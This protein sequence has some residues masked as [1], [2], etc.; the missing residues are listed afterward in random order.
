M[1]W[2]ESKRDSHFSNCKNIS[3]PNWWRCF[4]FYGRK[5]LPSKACLPAGRNSFEGGTNG[6][7]LKNRPSECP[8]GPGVLGN[9]SVACGTPG[10]GSLASRE[11]VLCF[12]EEEKL[13]PKG[14]FWGVSSSLT[15]VG[16]KSMRRNIWQHTFPWKRFD[17]APRPS[18]CGTRS[19]QQ[20]EVVCLSA[21]LRF[22]VGRLLPRLLP[23]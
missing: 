13:H 11:E 16:I 21:L 10:Q 17:P 12:L 8:A 23:K 22:R 9:A 19:L 18:G 3:C 14:F 1:S 6:L 20:V 2:F 4:C 7:E 15:R 5:W